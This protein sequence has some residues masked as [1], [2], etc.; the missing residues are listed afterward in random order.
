MASRAGAIAS[1]EQRFRWMLWVNSPAGKEEVRRMGF[2]PALPCYQRVLERGAHFYMTPQF[3]EL[4]D[5][6]RRTIP[7]DTRF[8]VNWLLAPMGFM[9]LAQPF[10]VPAIH[11]QDK[12][13]DSDTT[14]PGLIHAIGWERVPES[15]T[16]WVFPSNTKVG[17]VRSGEQTTQFTMFHF[18]PDWSRS[19]QEAHDPGFHAWSY[20]V[21]VHGEPV[22]DRIRS[23]EDA[24]RQG[25]EDGGAYVLGRDSDQLHE[26]RWVYTAMHIMSQRITTLARHEA[27]RSTRRRMERDHPNPPKIVDIVTLR[28]LEQDRSNDPKGNDVDWQWSWTVR[29]HWRHLKDGRRI[30]I[31]WYVKGPKDKPLKPRAIQIFSAER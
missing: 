19:D 5:Q 3:C 29:G 7:D 17:Q 9:W 6:A 11:V 22:I 4:V 21:T 1:L 16:L 31:H 14:K 12:V 8:D 20:F 25:G 30:R 18:Q 10:E 26:I 13:Q 27:D 23:F 2:G 15:E 28:R 24:C